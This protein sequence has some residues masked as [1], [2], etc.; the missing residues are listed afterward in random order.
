MS[1]RNL[2]RTVFDACGI[3]IKDSVSP[4]SGSYDIEVLD[5]SF[6]DRVL[7]EGSVGMGES[8]MEG[9]WSSDDKVTLVRKLM[10]FGASEYYLVVKFGW[11]ALVHFLSHPQ[12]TFSIIS[13]ALTTWFKFRYLNLQTIFMSKR[14]AEEVL[15]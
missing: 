14:V 8:Y 5:Q 13:S 11:L 9:L 4:C 6:Y 7:S 12:Q 10:S 2:I 15:L 1:C 3:V